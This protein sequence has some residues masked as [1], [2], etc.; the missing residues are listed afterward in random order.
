MTSQYRSPV[1]ASI[2]ETAEG[3]HAAGVMD[4]RT[5]QKFDDACLTPVCVLN[6]AEIRSLR[7]RER[8]SQ[9]VLALYLNVPTT[10]AA[11][12]A[13]PTPAAHALKTAPR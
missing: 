10:Q 2:H 12:S 4:K 5:T 13:R 8:A 11:D 7:E 1:M 3:F 6:P 9:A